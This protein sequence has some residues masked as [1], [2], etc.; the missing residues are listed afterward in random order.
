MDLRKY[1]SLLICSLV[2]QAVVLA[3]GIDRDGALRFSLGGEVSVL[4]PIL[5][6]DSVSSAVEGAIFSGLVTVNEKLEMVPDLAERWDISKDGKT[7]TFHLRKNVKWHDGVPFTA[8]DVKFTFDSI[9]NPKVN[10]VRRSDF[11]IDGKPIEFKVIDKNT[12]QAI[13]PQSFAPFLINVGIGII[14]KHLLAGKDINKADFNRRPIGTGPFMF[15]E[16]RSGDHVTVVRNPDYYLGQ[17]LLAQIVYKEIPDAN[18]RLVALEADE[19]DETEIPP[20][21]YERMKR[22]KG[23]NV[24]EY[25]AL[26]Y[27]YLGFNLASPKFA[28]PKVRQALAY[29]TDKKQLVDLIFK[30]LASPAYAP[31]APVSWAY[32]NKVPRYEFNPEKAKQ[33]LKEAGQ[34]DLEFTVL[35]NQ[36]NK[37]REKAAVILQQQYKKIG[38]RVKIRVLEWSALL[39]IVNAPKAPKDFDAVIMGWSLGLDPDAYSIWHSSQYPK[40][41]NFVNYNNPQVDKLLAAGRTTIKKSERRKIY[42]QIWNL[43]AADQPYIFLWYPKTVSGVRDRVGGL[44]QPG[45]A[46]LFLHLEKVFIKK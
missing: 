1:S 37:E 38:V 43:I 23:V 15:K 32:S 6:T 33:L 2:L 36:G 30:G 19:I 24:Y 12:V 28:N 5:S 40:G 35:V 8:D 11:I 7:W 42:R 29:A 34:E 39:K 10:S 22:A 16:W 14:P 45:P 27:T 4:N 25:D 18:S 20:K 46:G 3:A 31:S 21:D 44:S 17:P 9:L 26:L 41:F 13:L